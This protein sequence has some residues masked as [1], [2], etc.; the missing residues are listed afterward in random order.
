MAVTVIAQ[1]Q[2]TVYSPQQVNE[3]AVEHQKYASERQL[4][5]RDIKKQQVIDIINKMLPANFNLETKTA[6]IKW[7]DL[8]KSSKIDRKVFP[9]YLCQLPTN[10]FV[11]LFEEV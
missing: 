4:L 5:E 3:L 1:T 8:Q 7:K 9:D 2:S 10:E 6:M 11:S